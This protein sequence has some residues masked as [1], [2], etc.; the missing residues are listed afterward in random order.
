MFLRRPRGLLDFAVAVLLLWAAAYHTPIGALLRNTVALI[1]R[2]QSGAE[3]LLAYYSGGVYDAHKVQ[4]P[5]APPP[6][7]QSLVQTELSANEAL[8][9]ATASTPP[10]SPPT[11]ASARRAARSRASWAPT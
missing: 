6:P 5:I 3:P 4:V 9:Y 11:P 8:G 7:P 1:T 10:G 2:T